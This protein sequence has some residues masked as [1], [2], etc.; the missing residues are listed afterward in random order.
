MPDQDEQFDKLPRTIVDALRELDGPA[1]LPDAERD[2]DVLSGARQH[3]AGVA[4][5]NRKR[6]NLRLFFAGGAG[7]AVAAAAMIAIVVYMGDPV[8]DAEPAAMTMSDEAQMSSEPTQPTGDLD[9]SG[10]V[11]ILDAYSLARQIEQGQAAAALDFNGDGR[12]D[13]RD[14][15]LLAGRAVA[16]NPGERG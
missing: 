15:D 3:L 4:Q 12:V 14:V 10:G 6:R 7:G 16:L 13:Q 5:V 2:A 9:G 11:D 1:V 8:S